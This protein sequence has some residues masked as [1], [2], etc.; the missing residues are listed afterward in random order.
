[1]LLILGPLGMS[2]F[3][4]NM[5]VNTPLVLKVSVNFELYVKEVDRKAILVEHVRSHC[6]G[7]IIALQ[8]GNQT[9]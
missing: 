6:S 7:T 2:Y 3:V 5:Q 4:V 8:V 1:M 9:Q